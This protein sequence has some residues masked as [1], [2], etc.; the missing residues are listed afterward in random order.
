LITIIALIL[1]Y[2]VLISFMF[3][4]ALGLLSTLPM[5]CIEQSSPPQSSNFFAALDDSGDEAPVQV[6]STA[7]KKDTKKAGVVNPVEAS[8]VDQRCVHCVVV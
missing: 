5:P 3:P 1:L 6:P 2:V 8:K 7:V 4:T